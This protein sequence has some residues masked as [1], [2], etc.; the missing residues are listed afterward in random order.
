MWEQ[1]EVEFLAFPLFGTSLIQQLVAIAQGV[2]FITNCRL[3][4][5]VKQF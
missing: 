2:I 5:T 4:L 1:W 3:I